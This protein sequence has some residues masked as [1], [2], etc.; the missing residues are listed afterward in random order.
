MKRKSGRYWRDCATVQTGI[1]IS[2][3]FCFVFSSCDLNAFSVI[4]T[5]EKGF[6]IKREKMKALTIFRVGN[7]LP[8]LLFP[9]SLCRLWNLSIEKC[10]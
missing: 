7:L 9:A 3:L 8:L 10:F 2:P 5:L 1:V 4:D 6:L